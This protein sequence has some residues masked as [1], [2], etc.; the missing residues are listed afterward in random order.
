MSDEF[1]PDWLALREPYDRAARSRALATEFFAALPDRPRIADLGA[2]TG[3]N[4]RF[5]AGV[6]DKVI[7]WRLID[8]DQ[9]LLDR[10]SALEV[11]TVCADFA[12]SPD[13]IDLTGCHGV[14]ASALFDLVSEEWF[15][16]FVTHAKGL[17]MLIALTV[18]GRYAWEPKDGA[19]RLLMSRFETDMRRD[20]GFG[21]AMGFEA[22]RLMTKCLQRAGYKVTSAPSSWR[23]DRDDTE[24]LSAVCGFVSAVAGD[25]MAAETW[26]IRRNIA[27]EAKALR[28]TVGHVDIL[29][30][31]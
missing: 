6:S 1:A 7:A 24:L 29:A 3:S 30:L 19:D 13:R 14:T 16:R 15:G 11:E 31:P 9:D 27:I 21:P 8:R 22:P 17:P 5:L 2:G 23:L 26:R 10:V 12:P 25:G 28:L 4:A 20:K 18:D